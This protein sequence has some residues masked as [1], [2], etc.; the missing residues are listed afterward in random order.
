MLSISSSSGEGENQPLQ[1]AEVMVEALN[2]KLMAKLFLS[3]EYLMKS[4]LLSG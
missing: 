4:D 2:L 3:L 1:V